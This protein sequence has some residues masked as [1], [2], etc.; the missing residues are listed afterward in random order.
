MTKKNYIY[1]P[2][3]LSQVQPTKLAIR[4]FFYLYSGGLMVMV[5]GGLSYTYSHTRDDHDLACTR[6]WSRKVMLVVVGVGLPRSLPVPQ[7][8]MLPQQPHAF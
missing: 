2:A 8:T 6:R 1:I 3:S 4:F 5:C 7:L